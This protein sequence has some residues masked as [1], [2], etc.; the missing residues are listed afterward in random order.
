MNLGRSKVFG[1]SNGKMKLILKERERFDD[2]MA[3]EER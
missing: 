2:E 1:L 3:F